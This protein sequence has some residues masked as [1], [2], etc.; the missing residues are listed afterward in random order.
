MLAETDTPIATI[1]GDCGFYDQ[2][3]FTRRFARLTGTTPA[4]FRAHASGPSG[5]PS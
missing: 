1:A 3:D 4:Q 5:T 2:P